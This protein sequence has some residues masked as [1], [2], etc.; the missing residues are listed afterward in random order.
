MERLIQCPNLSYL[1]ILIVVM[2]VCRI[3]AKITLKFFHQGSKCTVLYWKSI[4]HFI[5]CG[6]GDLIVPYRQ[7]KGQT[8]YNILTMFQSKAHIIQTRH[9]SLDSS[10]A[11]SFNFWEKE[12]CCKMFFRYKTLLYY[13]CDARIWVYRTTPSTGKLFRTDLVPFSLNYGKRVNYLLT[14]VVA[15]ICTAS[16]TVINL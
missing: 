5:N 7:T 8:D 12:K 16:V 15:N 10:G 1:H 2:F 11:E 4:K 9:H 13:G 6:C 14:L 3:S